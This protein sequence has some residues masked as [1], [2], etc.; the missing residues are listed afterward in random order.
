VFENRVPRKIF[1]PE[2]DEVTGDWRR[3]HNEG[4]RNLSSLNIIPVS[5]SRKTRW[6]E[7]VA[8]MAERRRL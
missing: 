6:A 2:R 8:R 4:L 5:K 7:Q 1:R 3:W